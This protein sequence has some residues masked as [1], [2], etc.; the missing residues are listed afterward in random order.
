M[1][2]DEGSYVPEIFDNGNRV[3]L[4][5]QLLSCSACGRKMIKL[6]SSQMMKV[7]HLFPHYVRDN[8]KAQLERA[9]ITWYGNTKDKEGHYLCE[10]CSKKGL[11]TFLCALCGEERTS[12]LKEKIFGDPPEYL[13]KVCYESVPA[14]VWDKKTSELYDAHRWD[15]E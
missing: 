2:I 4:M 10:D 15:F 3:K 11:G 14:K 5:A 6:E 13:C 7:Y 9:N 8:L 12:D 1:R